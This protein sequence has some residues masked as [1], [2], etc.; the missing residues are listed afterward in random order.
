MILQCIFTV[1]ML[2][3]S[4]YPTY[5]I[6]DLDFIFLQNVLCMCPLDHLCFSRPQNV[7]NG[8]SYIFEITPTTPLGNKAAVLRRAFPVSP[9]ALSSGERPITGLLN[10]QRQINEVAGCSSGSHRVHRWYC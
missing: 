1:Y 3:A 9:T 6:L 7:A 4:L 10:L 8:I 5:F 2:C